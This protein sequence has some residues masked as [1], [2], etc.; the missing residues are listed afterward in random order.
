MYPPNLKTLEELDKQPDVMCRGGSVIISPFGEVI[1]GPLY[2]TLYADLDLSEIVKGK[3]DFDVVGHYARSD[4]F[5]LYVN[6]EPHAPVT[7]T[8]GKAQ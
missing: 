2:G 8:S 6:S 7:F 5:Q 3:V 1:A 4:I